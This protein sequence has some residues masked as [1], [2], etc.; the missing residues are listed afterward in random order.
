[1]YIAR[2]DGGISEDEWR[3]FVASEGFGHLVAAGKGR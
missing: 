1:M 3:E 2:V